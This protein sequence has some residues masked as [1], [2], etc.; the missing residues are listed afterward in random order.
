MNHRI[1]AQA[2]VFGAGVNS[3]CVWWARVDLRWIRSL[4]S[5]ICSGS[6]VKFKAGD[7]VCNSAVTAYVREARVERRA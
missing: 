3:M 4:Q 1:C 7:H 5:E 6:Y 2:V